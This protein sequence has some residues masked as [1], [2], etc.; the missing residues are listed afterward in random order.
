MDIGHDDVQ[1]FAL[2]AEACEQLIEYEIKLRASGRFFDVRSGAGIR[3]YRSG[4]RL[5]KWIEAD[6]YKGGVAG[7]GFCAL[8]WLELG[9]GNPSG[10]MLD[11]TLSVDPDH[12]YI[13]LPSRTAVTLSEFKEAL[14]AV[15]YELETALENNAEF[16]QAIET[17]RADANSI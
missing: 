4:W 11:A 14:A 15:V 6:I 2:F 17:A 12:S 3:N 13:S 9:P 10:L 5:E 1:L 16:I 8:W 7:G